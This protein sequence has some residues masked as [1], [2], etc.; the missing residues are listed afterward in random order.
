METIENLKTINNQLTNVIKTLEQVNA[1]K[2]GLVADLIGACQEIDTEYKDFC[3]EIDD[4]NEQ[5]IG[6]TYAKGI[7]VEWQIEADWWHPISKILNKI[8]ET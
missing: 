1:A 4:E 2:L 8:N 7:S 6:I 3:N 5:E